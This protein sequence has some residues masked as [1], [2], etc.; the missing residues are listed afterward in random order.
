[1]KGFAMNRSVVSLSVVGA[2]LIGVSLGACTVT[3]GEG[4]A[5]NF[6][7]GAFR[8]TG[9]TTVT[10]PSGS[11]VCNSCLFQGCS[12]QHAV[13]QSDSE[14]IAIYQCATAPTCT[15][16][17]CVNACFDAH[18]AGQNHYTALYTCDQRQACAACSTQCSV[19]SCA[20][21]T[22]VT[23]VDAGVERPDTSAPLDCSGCTNLR[24]AKEQAA[25]GPNS[26]CDVYSACVIACADAA[27]TNQCATT[28][29]VGKAASEALATCTGAQCKS[30]C[31]F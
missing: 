12:G 18:P 26:D 13:C 23:P 29:S 14:C 2:T 30:E 3:V 10:P 8:D 16:Q 11:P 22:P 25:C 19:A 15:T 5:S 24:C 27:C 17:A 31:G 4:S 21:V 9:S 1:M 6:D 7:G 28:H 20:P